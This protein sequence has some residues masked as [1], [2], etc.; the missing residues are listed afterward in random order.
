MP[1]VLLGNT[2]AIHGD[3]NDSLPG[4]RETHVH[5]PDTYTRQE[6]LRTIFHN[7]GLWVSHSSAPAPA[8]VECDDDPAL[9]EAISLITDCPVGRPEDWEVH[10]G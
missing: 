2:S 9:A 10:N 6:A 5:I 4:N 8:W 7:D 3:D 1:Q